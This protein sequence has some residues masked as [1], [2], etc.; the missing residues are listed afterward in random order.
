VVQ[1]YVC[2]EYASLPRPVKE[3]K[4]YCRLALQPGESKT[5]TFRLPVDL[6][7]FY[8]NDQKLIL[9]PGLI[10]VMLGSSSDDIR[11]KGDFEIDGAGKLPVAKRIFTCAVE[12]S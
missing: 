5:V 1:L 4:G 7:A 8:D 12:V 10:R 11:L 9:E 6:L 2:D 3:L